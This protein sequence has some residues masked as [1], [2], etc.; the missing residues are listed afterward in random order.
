MEGT[1][2]YQN[3]GLLMFRFVLVFSCRTKG[4]LYSFGI[5]KSTSDTNHQVSR[6]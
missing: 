6:W 2:K 3:T 4:P 5:E 1:T